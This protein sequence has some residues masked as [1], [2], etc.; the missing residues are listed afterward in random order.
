MSETLNETGKAFERLSSQRPSL[1][2]VMDIVAKAMKIS[3]NDIKSSSRKRKLAHARSL[4]S[5]AAVRNMGYKGT[6]VAKFLSLSSA[7]ISQNIDKGKILI[8]THEDLK[9]KLQ[10]T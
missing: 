2:E 7:T 6:E 4:V 1:E 10:I 5:Y 3:N 9:V 8:D